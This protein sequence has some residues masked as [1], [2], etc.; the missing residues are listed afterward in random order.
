M[1]DP[2]VY[3]REVHPGREPGHILPQA[4][5][6]PCTRAAAGTDAKDRMT[7]DHLT[8][9]ANGRLYAYEFED[10]EPWA[11]PTITLAECKIGDLVFANVSNWPGGKPAWWNLYE[12]VPPPS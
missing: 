5:E 9:R 1:A 12:I 11:A 2:A 4:Q 10:E 7:L 6:T 8:L 3:I